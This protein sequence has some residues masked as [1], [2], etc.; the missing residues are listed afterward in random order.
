MGW[1][2]EELG[3]GRVPSSCRVSYSKSRIFRGE[4]PA[5]DDGCGDCHVGSLARQVEKVWEHGARGLSV[6]EMG[7][8]SGWLAETRRAGCVCGD[9]EGR[10][11]GL[12]GHCTGREP[13]H[14]PR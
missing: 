13:K 7:S 1:E 6:Q 12:T 8:G 2:G 4:L 3:V 14:M 5:L 10:R 11:P 9:A